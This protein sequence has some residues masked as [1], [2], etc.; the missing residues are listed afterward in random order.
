MPKSIGVPTMG[1]V[2][3][4]LIDYAYGAG[5]G[6]VYSLVSSLL[7]SEFIGSLASAAIAG[8]VI[9]GIRGETI[10]TM[11]GFMGILSAMGGAQGTS[12][13]GSQGVM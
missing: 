9:K 3:A 1:G 7:G 10:A 8:S 13:G 6:L 12:T 5:G 4:S 2:K 11:L